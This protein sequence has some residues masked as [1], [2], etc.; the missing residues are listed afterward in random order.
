MTPAPEVSIIIPA[1]RMASTLDECL[2]S[3]LN[4]S[5]VCIE[6][7]VCDGAGDDATRAVIDRYSKQS[8]RHLVEPDNGVYDAMNKG[9]NLAEGEWIYFI[10][11]DDHLASPQAL[12]N[13]L[14]VAEPG[15]QLLLGRVKNL[16]PR[17]RMVSEWHLPKW[18]QTL[19]LKNTVH[20]QG[21]LYHRS[22][23]SDYRYPSELH[24]LGDYHLNLTLYIAGVK[25]SITDIHIASCAQGGLSKRFKPS[26]YREEWWLK[27]A[28]LPVGSKWWQPFWLMLKYLRK[29][30]H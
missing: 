1:F 8:I 26:L 17:H 13:L 14:Q 22:V 11:A 4:S 30:L 7:I 21:A 9:I 19:L 12:Q 28:I 10:G 25:A 16:P 18:D 3:I 23:F 15:V 6:V 20:H 27:R 29:Q 5:G 24:V 2:K